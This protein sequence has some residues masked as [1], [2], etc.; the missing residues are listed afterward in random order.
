MTLHIANVSVGYDY[1]GFSARFSFRF[2]GNVISK[3]GSHLEGNEYTNDSYTYD[4]VVKQKIPLKF[5]DFEVFFNA[6]NFTN[7][8][9]SRYSIYPDKGE[10]NTFTSYSGAQFQLG[11]RLRH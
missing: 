6:I 2:Q 9:K 5:A 1:K 10:T 3:I 7:V 11:L 4:F 8:P